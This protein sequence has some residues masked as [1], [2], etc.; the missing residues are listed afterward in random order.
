MRTN[1][2]LKRSRTPTTPAL[3]KSVERTLKCSSLPRENSM[4]N[5]VIVGSEMI[6]VGSEEEV[7]LVL[8]V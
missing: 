8:D 3:Y 6:R 4:R 5:S 1:P 2:E 7:R